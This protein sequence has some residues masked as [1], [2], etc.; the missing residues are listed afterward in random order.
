MARSSAAAKS[1][2][3]E[4]AAS[5][6]ASGRVDPV[7]AIRSYADRIAQMHF[8]EQNQQQCRRWRA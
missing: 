2:L 8:K 1:L 4:R 6:T 3:C 7:P 5:P